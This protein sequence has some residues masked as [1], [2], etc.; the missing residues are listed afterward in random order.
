MLIFQKRY[1]IGTVLTSLLTAMIL[2]QNHI[3]ITYYTL[4]IALAIGIAY[5]V[6]A[7]R[8]GKVKD[9]IIAGALALF[10]GL[11]SHWE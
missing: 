4:I 11:L 6:Y 2:W 10:S 8:N 7:I 5:S 9:V 1:V 3:Q